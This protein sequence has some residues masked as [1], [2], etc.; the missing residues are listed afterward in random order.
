MQKRFKISYFEL[1]LCWSW[2]SVSWPEEKRNTVNLKRLARRWLLYLGW[3]ELLLVSIVY[4][5]SRVFI[6]QTVLKVLSMC[7]SLT[8]EIKP[9]VR[10]TN[11]MPTTCCL[12]TELYSKTWTGLSAGTF[13]NSA[14]HIRHRRTRRLIRVCTVCFNYGKLMVK[15]NSLVP[16]R[17]PS[18]NH[19][20]IILTYLNPTFM[21]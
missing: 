3:L 5:R 9:R 15:W 8:N 16:V 20:Y 4:S 13:A 7:S 1:A 14:E 21:K 19:A 2:K 6:H 18:R 17:D 12:R 11:Q 10:R